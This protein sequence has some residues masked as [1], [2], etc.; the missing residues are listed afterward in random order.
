MFSRKPLT[1]PTKAEALPGR[2]ERM[3]VPDKHFVNGNRL[4]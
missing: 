3:P 4:T 2:S 1:I